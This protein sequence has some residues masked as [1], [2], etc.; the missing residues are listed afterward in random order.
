MARNLLDEKFISITPLQFSFCVPFLE[1]PATRLKYI[2]FIIKKKL[3]GV[4]CE[5][6]QVEV[7]DGVESFKFFLN[8]ILP[9]FIL[10]WMAPTC[11]DD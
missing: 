1:Q 4:I 5:S 10:H 6:C 9:A 3:L 11:D 8:S 7:F 2:K